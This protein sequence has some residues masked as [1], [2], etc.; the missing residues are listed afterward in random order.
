MS[1]SYSNIFRKAAFALALCVWVFIAFFVCQYIVIFLWQA[2]VSLHIFPDESVT[3][4][5]M[6]LF[7]LALS[8]VLALFVIVSLPRLVD[9]DKVRDIKKRLGISKKPSLLDLL[10]SVPGYGVYFVLTIALSIL[11][12]S[13]WSGFDAEQVQE[14]GFDNLHVVGEYLLAFIAL[15]IIPPIAE[16][17]LFRGYV[18]SRLRE[19]T[20]FIASTLVTSLLFG[21]VHLQWNVG[22]DVFALSLVL[23]YLRERTGHIWAGVVLHM[24][25]NGIAFTLLF[26]YPSFLH[27]LM[28]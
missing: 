3:S 21:I 5:A 16:E 22:I 8:Y 20:G 23:C 10:L 24:I 25:K 4:P 6:Q 19:K 11:I 1:L 15:V 13:V 27:H 28:R 17:M 2:V 9:L 18:Y 26:V 7:V 14:V 12:H